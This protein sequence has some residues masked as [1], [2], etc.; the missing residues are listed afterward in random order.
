MVQEML[1][2]QIGSAQASGLDGVREVDGELYSFPV[3]VK[4]DARDLSLA[5]ACGAEEQR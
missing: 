2:V 4:V 1:E 3:V 5:E